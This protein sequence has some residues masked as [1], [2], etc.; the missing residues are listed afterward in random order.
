MKLM[1]TNYKEVRFDSIKDENG[2]DLYTKAS[3]VYDHGMALSK[4]GVGVKSEGQLLIS[5]QKGTFSQNRHG[6]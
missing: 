1:G 4:S 5:E 3:F 6:G 2:I